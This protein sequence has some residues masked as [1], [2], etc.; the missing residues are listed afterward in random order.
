MNGRNSC[1]RMLC[2][3]GSIKQGP[4][5]KE[6]KGS[7]FNLGP[8]RFFYCFVSKSFGI[9][10]MFVKMPCLASIPFLLQIRFC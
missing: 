6:K 2:R 9:K 3:E 4:G 1:E 7:N 10:M 5:T 8:A